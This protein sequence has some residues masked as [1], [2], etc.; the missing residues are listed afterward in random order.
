MEKSFEF[1]DTWFNSQKDSVDSWLGSQ[2]ELM[3]N[4]IKAAKKIQLSSGTMA[5]YQ[6]GSPELFDFLNSWFNTDSMND[7]PDEFF[8]TF[9]RDNEKTI[10]GCGIEQ[11]YHPNTIILD[12]GQ[13]VRA[14]HLIVDGLVKL[15]HSEPNGREIIVGIRNRY[16]LLGAP[17]LFLEKPCS[18]TA[19]TLI[20][21]TIRSIK[22]GTFLSL[23]ETDRIFNRN[24]CRMI[25]KEIL[26][27]L[28]KVV[29][30]RTLP[31]QD[32]LMLFLRQFLLE[33]K[34]KD[35][36]QEIEIPLKHHELADM[37][38]VTPQ[39]FCRILQSLEEQGILRRFKRTL[40]IIQP[41]ILLRQMDS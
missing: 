25:C 19:T 5:A 33:L 18:F 37:I 41:Q 32:R 4:W 16:W 12:Q 24:V 21:C 7:N 38:G 14:L 22:A 17:P 20:N 40:F 26:T 34:P 8:V 10:A 3:D 6:R 31:C 13:T 11:P 15:I 35:L 1:Y 36:A 39:H 2:K 27:H 28:F 30:V 23:M 29:E 9:F